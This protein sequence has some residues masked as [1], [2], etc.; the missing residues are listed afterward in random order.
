MS[1]FSRLLA[2]DSRYINFKDPIAKQYVP[3]DFGSTTG[4]LKKEDAQVVFTPYNDSFISSTKMRYFKGSDIRTFNEFSYFTGATSVPSFEGCK[5]FESIKIPSQIRKIEAKTFKN[6]SNLETINIPSNVKLMGSEVFYGCK[7][8]R[9]TELPHTLTAVEGSTF[10]GCESLMV[11]DIST[12]KSTGEQVF[13]NCKNAPLSNIGIEGDSILA[14]VFSGCE[15][16]LFTTIPSNIKRI[17]YGVFRNCKKSTFNHVIP[18]HIEFLG[19]YSFAGCNAA[20]FDH[21]PSGITSNANI[22]S[23]TFEGCLG[24]T[25]FTWSDNLTIIPDEIFKG[26]TN[27]QSVNLAG[28]TTIGNGSFMNCSRLANVNLQSITHIGN[29]AFN[30]CTALPSSIRLDSLQSIGSTPFLN[31]TRLQKVRLGYNGVV[32]LIG[33]TISGVMTYYYPFADNVEVYVSDVNAYKSAEGWNTLYDKVFL[34]FKP[35]SEWTD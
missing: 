31:C 9:L 26:C 5:Y 33:Q 23:N 30:R 19:R 10:Y 16:A 24:I 8:L 7:K 22:S 25:E 17:L 15:N 18:D 1:I 21:L 32:S 28:C 11:S 27:L 3:A 12:I 6:C 14:N 2:G 29:N 35:L 34:K 13:M 4:R 20:N